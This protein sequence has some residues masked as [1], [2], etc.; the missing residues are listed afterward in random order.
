M[1]TRHRA[2]ILV[3]TVVVA[4]GVVT[5]RAQVAPRLGPT[6]H[7]P[8]PGHPSLYWLL[9]DLSAARTAAARNDEALSRLAR[10]AKLKI[11]RAHV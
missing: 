4:A 5:S 1:S 8:L 11:G 6:S 7:P 10:G 9:P 2:S 3:L